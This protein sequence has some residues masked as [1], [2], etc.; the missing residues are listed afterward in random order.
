[1]I[2]FIKSL[3]TSYKGIMNHGFAKN[4]TYTTSGSIW[5]DGFRYKLY[6]EGG[7]G[8]DQLVRYNGCIHD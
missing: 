5:T 3:F 1:M 7:A 8:G 2:K 6:I 4:A